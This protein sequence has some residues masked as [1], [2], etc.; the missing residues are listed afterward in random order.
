LRERIEPTSIQREREQAVNRQMIGSVLLGAILGLIAGY[1]YYGFSGLTLDE[2]TTRVASR[3]L[4]LGPLIGAVLGV[5]FAWST[6]VRR[7]RGR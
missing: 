6:K 2:E 1:F 7:G 5:A 4:Y 3:A